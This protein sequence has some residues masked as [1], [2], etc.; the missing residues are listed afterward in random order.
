MTVHLR[1]R[2]ARC[3]PAP[4][5]PTWT[6][7]PPRRARRNVSEPPSSRALACM[8]T[9]PRCSPVGSRSAGR[10]QA[11]AHLLG[12]PPPSSE[13]VRPDRVAAV[14][15]PHHGP[16]RLRVHRGVEQR[17]AGDPEQRLL[18]V[19][20]QRHRLAPDAHLDLQLVGH[21]H[22]GQPAQHRR[23][24]LVG[25]AAVGVAAA[26]RSPSAAAR[27]RAGSGPWPCPA[28]PAAARR[29]ISERTS[30]MCM[31]ADSAYWVTLS[32]SSRAIRCRSLSSTS[33]C[34]AAPSSAWVSSSS[35]LRAFERVG[36]AGGA[37]VEPLGVVEQRAVL[38][39]GRGLARPGSAAPSGRC[40]RSA[41]PGGVQAMTAPTTPAVQPDRHVQVARS[42][43][44][45]CTS[46]SAPRRTWSQVPP[47][48][49]RHLG[50]SAVASA[51]SG[52]RTRWRGA[53]SGSSPS[54]SANTTQ[55]ADRWSAAASTTARTSASEPSVV[56]TSA[57]EM[58]SSAW[59]TRCSRSAEVRYSG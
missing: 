21:V 14:G 41:A 1:M 19:G 20:R 33:R 51:P 3:R 29:V 10:A 48:R 4:G 2:A 50:S 25:P 44:A 8:F 40:R 54:T 46:L 15:Q 38:Q 58:R 31:P 37:Y 43:S 5:R 6:C 18:A 12:P 55:S 52:P 24:V 13:I 56:R 17:L 28:A 39:G 57:A 27:R 26:R 9:R 32:C 11:A 35:S 23:Q 53:A 30:S 47:H 45:S 16:A 36:L 49:G 7:R 22:A 59:I 34:R 42:E